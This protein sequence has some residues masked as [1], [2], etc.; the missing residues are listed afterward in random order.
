MSARLGQDAIPPEELAG[1]ADL[2]P[3]AKLCT[4]ATGI[5]VRREPWPADGSTV[6]ESELLPPWRTP[7][8][9]LDITTLPTAPG[10]ARVLA[11]GTVCSPMMFLHSAAATP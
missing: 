1:S 6:L 3:V 11:R 9:Q 2:A 4:T 7:V 8:A 10:A 5:S